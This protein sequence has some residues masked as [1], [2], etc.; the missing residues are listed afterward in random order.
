[1]GEFLREGK[2]GKGEGWPV[3]GEKGRK[4]ICARAPSRQRKKTERDNEPPFKNELT[5][6]ASENK[7]KELWGEDTLNESQKR[8]P[9]GCKGRRKGGIKRGS[10]LSCS[11]LSE[12]EVRPRHIE[13]ASFP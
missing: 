7:K 11:S 1:L 13:S 3:G 5:R 8:I 6:L 4:N 2:G 10:T 9:G 12:E